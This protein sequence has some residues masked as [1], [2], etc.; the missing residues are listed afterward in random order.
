MTDFMRSSIK[1][2]QKYFR[3]TDFGT[4]SAFFSDEK[5]KFLG[6]RSKGSGSLT[7]RE[8]RRSR[9]SWLCKNKR[10][11]SRCSVRKNRFSPT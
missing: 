11:R 3:L 8:T 9:S 4:Q 10:C 6:I 5:L 1:M 2:N 7:R